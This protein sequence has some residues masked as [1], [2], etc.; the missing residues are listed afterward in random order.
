MSEAE[1][2]SA[3]HGAL[4]AANTTLF[5]YVS[6]MSGFLVMSYLGA[7]RLPAFLASIVVALFSLVSGLL[8][9]QIFLNRNDAQAIASYMFEEKQSGN[10]DLSWFG[11]NPFW[12]TTINQY[13][14]L[15]VAVG[16][17]LGC[18]AFFF[19]QRRAGVDD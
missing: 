3:F 16:G 19:Y 5:G 11:S 14:M 1:L 10:L 13:L 18:I 17:F 12:A 15:A 8:I 6:L 9:F 4:G 2:Y 7:H